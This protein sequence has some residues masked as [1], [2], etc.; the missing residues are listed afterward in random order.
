MDRRDFYFLQPVTEGELNGAF[1]AVEN[2][3]LNAIIDLGLTGIAWGLAGS[4]LSPPTLVVRLQQGTAFDASGRRVHVV[5]AE[6]P[7]IPVD[8]SSAP[9]PDNSTPA[10]TAVSTPGNEKWVSV[11]VQFLRSNGSPPDPRTDGAGNPIQF[12]QDE[13][14]QVVVL[15][16][17]EVPLG[18]VPHAAPSIDPS[19]VLCFDVHLVYG[20]TAIQASDIDISRRQ[21]A[22]VAGSAITPVS[23]RA[24]TAPGAIQALVNALNTYLTSSASQFATLKGRLDALSA[25]DWKP[26]LLAAPTTGYNAL[27]ATKWDPIK[28]QWLLGAGVNTGT[29]ACEVFFGYGLND[30]GDFSVAVSDGTGIS[31]VGGGVVHDVLFDGTKY[32]A[33]VIAASGAQAIVY[34]C[35]PGGAWSVLFSNPDHAYTTA[36]LYLFNGAVYAFLSSA[37]GNELSYST[38]HGATWHPFLGGTTAAQGHV[39]ADNGSYM[40]VMPMAV[41]TLLSPTT[42]MVG[43]QASWQTFAL[44]NGF[45]NVNPNVAAVVGLVYC[46]GLSAFFAVTTLTSGGMATFRSPDGITWTAVGTIASF[47]PIGLAAVGSVLAV[48]TGDSGSGSFVIFSIDGGVTWRQ[49]QAFLPTVASPLVFFPKIAG[50]DIGLLTMNQDALR[51]GHYSGLPPA[52]S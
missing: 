38:D 2:A 25:I 19:M 31:P 39:I 32:Y 16:G 6:V 1:D 14:F 13:S 8:C 15:Q 29:G 40:V 44:S 4:P 48:I 41:G 17:P 22:F 51:V 26:K 11:F 30:S 5:G 34:A 43:S 10:S 3:M 20:Q 52:L 33:V 12:E 37:A 47:N 35:S 42:Y 23:L 7:S 27:L 50:S 45:L 46:P 9:T 21:D 28:R 24:G 49:T 18:T 36:K